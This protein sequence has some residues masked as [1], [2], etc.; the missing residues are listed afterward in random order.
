M[1][2]IPKSPSALIDVQT[3]SHDKGNLGG[4]VWAS[5]V[6]V[7]IWCGANP[8]IF[9]GQRVLEL[10]SGVGLGGLC[11]LAVTN[12]ASVTLSDWDKA[13]PS[14]VQN[15][16]D[17]ANSNPRWSDDARC[18][19]ELFDWQ[20]ALENSFVAKSRFGV[21]VGADC[22]YTD[23]PEIMLSLADATWKHLEV[24]EADARPSAGYFWL[25][26]RKSAKHQRGVVMCL[27]E[28][29]KHGIIEVQK[30]TLTNFAVRNWS[31]E[32]LPLSLV[33]FTPF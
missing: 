3:L 28:L 24:R 20:D 1:F 5:A 31:G 22:M 9:S 14:L 23:Q 30:F 16:R 15:L 13:A 25:P 21:I 6:A 32:T 10:G 2:P 8:T 4:S 33:T 17:N 29:K 19:V 7:G 27:A 18:Y 26:N 12:A 11:A